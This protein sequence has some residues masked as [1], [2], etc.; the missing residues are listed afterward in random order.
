MTNIVIT[1]GVTFG[2]ET[3][4]TVVG[5]DMS[6]P[7]IKNYLGA[8]KTTMLGNNF[9]EYHVDGPPR[10]ET[11]LDKLE[12]IS[13][14]VVSVTGVDQTLIWSVHKDNTMWAEQPSRVI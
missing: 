12:N 10:T 6:G 8:R 2:L 4:A 14:S 13:I 1:N 9:E 3:G 5:D 11:V 7:A